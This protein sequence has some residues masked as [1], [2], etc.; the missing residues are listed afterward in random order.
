MCKEKEPSYKLSECDK[1]ILF[2]QYHLDSKTALLNNI[3]KKMKSIFVG[4]LTLIEFSDVFS[5]DE[6]K[7]IRTMILDL[8]ND[9]VRSIR[10]EIL[11][12]Y[13]VSFVP[14]QIMFKRNEEGM[15]VNTKWEGVKEDE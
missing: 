7:K 15:L 6:L 1:E 8:G 13:N 4:C 12:R 3:E 2:D 14:H 10:R 9:K 5:E 11:Q